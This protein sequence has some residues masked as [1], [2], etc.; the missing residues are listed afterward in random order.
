[1]LRYRPRGPLLF[2]RTTI[3]PKPCVHNRAQRPLT[4]AAGLRDSSPLS[5]QLPACHC[6][7]CLAAWIMVTP[8]IT[9]SPYLAPRD[10]LRTA[11]VQRISFLKLRSSVALQ[12]SSFTRTAVAAP[13][14][15]LPAL[16][17]RQRSRRPMNPQMVISVLGALTAPVVVIAA[18]GTLDGFGKIA[19]NVPRILD[20]QFK[21]AT[22]IMAVGNGPNG[23]D[24]D[25]LNV[26]RNKLEQST[27]YRSVDCAHTCAHV[28]THTQSFTLDFLLFAPTLDTST[29][30]RQAASRQSAGGQGG[31]V[32]GSACSIQS[33]AC[34]T[35]VEICISAGKMPS[36]CL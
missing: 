36:V 1:M 2:M 14:P 27:S 23:L 4:C 13:T 25:P 15:L 28:H 3:L 22:R 7:G 35:A 5:L 29:R 26:F 21:Y 19:L 18:M 10:F 9:V 8:E 12:G 34:A 24:L 33:S 31:A 30:C 20:Y 6:L 16:S 32:W 17:Q 11:T